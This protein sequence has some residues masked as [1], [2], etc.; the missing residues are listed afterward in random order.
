MKRHPHCQHSIGKGQSA[1]IISKITESFRVEHSLYAVGRVFRV[2][3][4]PQDQQQLLKA[5]PRCVNV[6][7]ISM[8]YARLSALW[9]VR[10]RIASSWWILCELVSNGQIPYQGIPHSIASAPT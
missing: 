1:S 10:L 5:I 2:F 8:M 3:S 4:E 6:A 9:W 7:R